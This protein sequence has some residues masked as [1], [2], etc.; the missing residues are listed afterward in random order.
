MPPRANPRISPV[1]LHNMSCVLAHRR[2]CL[3]IAPSQITT[4]YGAKFKRARGIDARPPR[5]IHF[6]LKQQQV[7]WG[8]VALLYSHRQTL[9]K[10]CVW[11]AAIPVGWQF[12][13]IQ[14]FQFSIKVWVYGIV[15]WPLQIDILQN[16]LC[17]NFRILTTVV[18]R[19]QPLKG[20][21]PAAVACLAG[22]DR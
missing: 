4:S 16:V 18:C 11:N 2:H 22:I 3:N 17:T 12:L 6:K 20:S 7:R 9:F 5:D 1:G 8:V 10:G 15:H 14:I 21:L 13:A 19:I